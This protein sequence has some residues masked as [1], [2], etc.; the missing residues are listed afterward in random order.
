[1]QKPKTK[2]MKRV[3]NFHSKHLV[4]QILK[5]MDERPMQEFLL[6]SFESNQIQSDGNWDKSGNQTKWEDGDETNPTK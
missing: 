3:L 6:S 1:M 4:V 5:M 2:N